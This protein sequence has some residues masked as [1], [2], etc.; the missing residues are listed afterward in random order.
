MARIPEPE[1]ERL[2]SSV[3]LTRLIESEG[4]TLKR[5]GKDWA[6]AC[7]FH[8]GD[9]EP[10]LIVSP[11]KNLF[12]CFACGAAGSPIDWLMQRRGVAFRRAVEL[13]RGMLDGEPETVAEVPKAAASKIVAPL[14]AGED[15]A[16]LLREVVAHYHAALKDSPEA[17]EY[18]VKRGLTHPELIERFQL[19]FANRTLGYRLP[20]KQV[21]SGAA[22]RQQLQRLGV[23]RASGHEHLNGSLVIPV[24]DAEGQVSELYGRKITRDS[25]LTA[26]TPLHLYLPGPHRGVFNEQGLVGQEEVILCEA[27]LDALTFWCAGYR[28][29]TASYGVEGFTDEI[30]A[31]IQRHG[32]KRV[33]IAYDADEAGNRA[34]EKLAQRLMADGLD[35]YRCRF[36]KG[37]DANQYALDVQPATKSLGLVIRQAEWL[38]N[39]LPRTR[40]G[41]KAPER[42]VVGPAT[43]PVSM[44]EAEVSLLVA[45][46]AL[47]AVEM[48]DALAAEA[49]DEAN[50]ALT[51]EASPS[52]PEPPAYRVP[53]SEPTLPVE[54][55]AKELRLVLGDRQYTVRGLDKN[56]SY[57][58]LKVWL[59]AQW[60]DHLHVDTVE[61]YQAKQRAVWIR[62][63]AVELGVSE[64][65]IKGD[66]AK[67]LRALEAQQDALIRAKLAPKEPASTPTLTPAQQ[68]DALALLQAPD[69]IARIVSDFER[70]GLVGEPNNALVGYLAAVSR[71]LKQPLAVLIQSTSAAGKST[72]MDAVLNFMPEAERVQY[73]AMTGQS[74]FYLGEKDLQHKILAIAEEEGVRQAAYALKLLQSQGSLTMASTGKDPVTGQLVTQDYRVDGPVMLFLTTTASEVDEELL[75]RCLVLTIDESREQT[76]AILQRQRQARTLAGLRA[77][78]EAERIVAQ[79]RAAQSLL[80]PLA[81]VNPYAEALGF[82]D[83]L[84]RLRRDH[85]KYLTLIESIALLHQHQRPIRTLVEHGERIEYVEVTAADIALANRLAHEVLGRSLDDLP[86]HTRRVL[87]SIQALVAARAAEQQVPANAVRF[88]RREVRAVAGMSEKQ[89]RVHVERLLDLEYLLAHGGRTGQRFVYELVFD[90]DLSDSAPRVMGLIDPATDTTAHLVGE[91]PHLVGRSWPGSGPL[92]GTS[93]SLET[94]RNASPGAEFSSL[95]AAVEE[96]A[97]FGAANTPRRN[98]A[99]VGGR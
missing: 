25:K 60:G 4:L 52:E 3:A 2:R 85:Q 28:N 24:F 13:L 74:L 97:L 40:S 89:V 47:D 94:V 86:P 69:L 18:L 15:D 9:H 37:L 53:P 73:S 63:T 57:E 67:L 5:T 20:M 21:K 56:L 76:R 26:G 93:S 51:A 92:V 62:Q 44:G 66:L 75:N 80:R 32:V 46:S 98:G 38:G 48:T 83:D 8:D 82:R 49:L 14:T 64:D 87:G 19:G 29:V 95:V 11:D 91:T 58:Q 39:G 27:L 30:A 12:H 16:A 84:T 54:G 35:C 77:D 81:V 71:K 55:D 70:A 50:D 10:S 1:V 31:A 88:T 68:R 78:R 36:P 17:R 22:I 72:L 42:G 79:H 34:A 33:L 65:L 90:G 43:E 96:N 41:G 23:L 6:C 99:V 45:G 59:K 61:L 7:P